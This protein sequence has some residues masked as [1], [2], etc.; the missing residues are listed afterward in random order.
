MSCQT[1]LITLADLQSRV[2][3][4]STLDVD[5]I[6]PY[7][8]LAQDLHLRKYLCKPFFDEIIQEYTD[9]DFSTANQSL[10]DDY[11]KPAL[12]YRSYAL[13]LSEANLHVK[14]SGVRLF[15]EDDS[16]ESTDSR[17]KSMVSRYEQTA[18]S[19]ENFLR[20]HLE[21]NASTYPT[22]YANCDRCNTSSSALKI[23][24]IGKTR[25]NYDQY[26]EVCNKCNSP[27]CRCF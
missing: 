5:D 12:V 8:I 3:I 24:S 19:F 10:Y 7:I 1:L 11:I 4:S 26:K 18:N 23:T 16:Q 9:D 21:D 2:K 17:L 25:T 27:R 6:K 14:N 15:T 20:E 13:Y 22:Y